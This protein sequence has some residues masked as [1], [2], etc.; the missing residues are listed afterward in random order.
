[1]SDGGM[2]G[3]DVTRRDAMKTALKAG[4]YAA[5]VVLASVP[6]MGVA[7]ASPPPSTI[8]ITGIVPPGGPTIGGTVVTITGTN[9]CP[10][11]IVT[12]NGV[13]ATT[14]N[15]VNTTTIIFTTP[16]GT[17]GTA[18]ITVTCPAGAPTAPFT[19]HTIT[20]TGEA[21]GANASVL[22]LLNVS[23]LGDVT[24]PPGGTNTAVALNLP[25]VLSLGVIN[26]SA[27]NISNTTPGNVTAQSN[28]TIASANLLA[29]AITSTVI[30]A[31]STSTS[32]GITASS[33]P[34]FS[35]IVTINGTNFNLAT[36]AVNTAVTIPGI[37]NVTLNRVVTNTTGANSSETVTAVYV[38]LLTL[39]LNGVTLEIATAISGV[40]ST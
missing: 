4:A 15:V 28:S 25:G 5:P 6:A 36:V 12:V 40:T 19:Y 38:A 39:L 8:T 2:F 11:A 30:T 32:N 26:N 29:G 21:Y 17:V 3:K 1:M 27:Q 35:G 13:V 22:G 37:A 7:A 31:Q 20:A 23:K 16:P 10:G 34:A 18:T 9:F 24:L 33:T 14:V